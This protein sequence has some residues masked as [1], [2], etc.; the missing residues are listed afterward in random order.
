MDMF[1]AIIVFAP[2]LAP[3]A[4]VWGGQAAFR[5]VDACEFGIGIFNSSGWCEFIYSVFKVWKAFGMGCKS[6]CAKFRSFGGRRG[7][8]HVGPELSLWLPNLIRK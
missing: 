1:S 5:S 7:V 2:I 3:L 4:Y 8:D 6:V